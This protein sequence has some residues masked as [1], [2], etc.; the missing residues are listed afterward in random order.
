M[1]HLTFSLVILIIA[2]MLGAPMF[3]QHKQLTF[4]SAPA[5]KVTYLQS[6]P[7][8]IQLAFSGFSPQPCRAFLLQLG[9]GGKALVMVA[10]YLLES[11]RTVFFVPEKGE[12]PLNLASKIYEEGNEFIESMGFVLMESDFHLLSAVD[13]EQY[14]KKLPITQ[15]PVATVVKQQSV[16]PSKNEEDLQL[17][18]EKSLASLGRFMSSL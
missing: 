8:A 4:L 3:I 15:P 9:G 10:F 2:T 14:W 1:T 6:S 11:R 5:T 18:R 13:K 17:L 12:T 16:L 7:S